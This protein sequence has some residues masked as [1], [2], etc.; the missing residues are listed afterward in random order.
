MHTSPLYK[1][2]SVPAFPQ[3]SFIEGKKL[4]YCNI[5]V[6]SGVNRGIS[7]YTSMLVTHKLLHLSSPISQRTDCTH[8]RT[9]SFD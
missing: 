6:Q 7:V 3:L 4:L 5:H 2:K 9:N 8:L 1:R